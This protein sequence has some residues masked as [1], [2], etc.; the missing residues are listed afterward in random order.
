MNTLSILSAGDESKIMAALPVKD[1]EWDRAESISQGLLSLYNGGLLVAHL[2][3]NPL[4][5]LYP[6]S[7]FRDRSQAQWELL[8]QQESFPDPLRVSIRARALGLAPKYITEL[9]LR[10][11]KGKLTVEILV[12]DKVV[13]TGNCLSITYPNGAVKT[14]HSNDLGKPF[15]DICGNGVNM[16][17]QGTYSPEDLDRC[18]KMRVQQLE[19]DLAGLRRD[20]EKKEDRLSLWKVGEISVV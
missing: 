1:L 9:D 19:C 5:I 2:N 11:H 18:R 8:L 6:G 20:I 14:L 16:F 4:N 7:L 12:H 10:D 17:V 3:P 15:K 13:W